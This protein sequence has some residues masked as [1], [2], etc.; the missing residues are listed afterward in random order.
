[1]HPD[2]YF[3]GNNGR[4]EFIRKPIAEKL[5]NLFTSG[6]DVSPMVIDGHWGMGKSEFCHKT[7]NLFRDNV[8]HYKILYIDAFKADH[9]DNPLLTILS[10][11]MNAYPST[12]NNNRELL[13]AI[14]PVVRHTTQLSIKAIANHIF[15]ED[16]E[17]IS[18]SYE[19]IVR[20][21]GN[22][23]I[24]RSVEVLLKDH[25]EAKKNIETLQEVLEQLTKEHPMVIFIDE[26][27]RCRPNFAVQMIEVIKHI[28]DVNNLNFVLVTN[29][30]QLRASINHCYGQEVDAQR[31]LDKFIKFTVHL[32]SNVNNNSAQ[33]TLASQRLFNSLILQS[34][35]F[36]NHKDLHNPDHSMFLFCQE[37]IKRS[38]LSLREVESFIRHLE[39]YQ[40]L[41]NNTGIP[42]KI[43]TLHVTLSRVLAVLIYSCSPNLLEKI[44]SEQFSPN[45]LYCIFKI[46]TQPH[47]DPYENIPSLFVSFA[48]LLLSRAT[49]NN[50]QFQIKDRTNNNWESHIKSLRMQ[51]Y[52]VRLDPFDEIRKVFKVLSL[53]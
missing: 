29:M 28:F 36:K 41:T 4:D 45:D 23:A 8:P 35:H 18:D 11:V 44:T 47:I 1:M 34:K 22:K 13:N 7:I 24:D 37:L 32:S 30:N 27:D 16:L 38:E 50:N 20:S 25:Q 43:N 19:E 3:D 52:L 5:I 21:V 14:L 10:E 26:L 48:V 17:N 51:D 49:I 15:K 39:I 9:A 42:D 46:T 33:K 31:Y 40:Q 6:I 2:W 53:N 12:S